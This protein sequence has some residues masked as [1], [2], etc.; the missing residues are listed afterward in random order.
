MHRFATTTPQFYIRYSFR[1][2]EFNGSALIQTAIYRF[3]LS[4]MQ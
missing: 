4:V 2:A 3:N 1:Y